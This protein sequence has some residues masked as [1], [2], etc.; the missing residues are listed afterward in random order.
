MKR[1]ILILLAANF[2]IAIMIG[3][4]KSVHDSKL[5]SKNISDATRVAA[6][7]KVDDGYKS[8]TLAQK[9]SIWT[10]EQ[11]STK[12]V[13][14]GS[15][16]GG[17]ALAAPIIPKG[18]LAEGGGQTGGTGFELEVDFNFD[19]MFPYPNYTVSI[20]FNMTFTVGGGWS[21]TQVGYNVQNYGAWIGGE[22][23]IDP[24][25]YVHFYNNSIVFNLGISQTST[26]GSIN[27]A[28]LTTFSGWVQIN[29]DKTVGSGQCTQKP[30]FPKKGL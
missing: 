23:K 13:Y 4:N 1:T 25:S 8:L 18:T 5:V 26:F 11:Y 6:N 9:E 12:I 7:P 2:T 16:S 14:V 24:N 3:C 27:N 15:S 29:D 21:I 30:K 19:N 22:L 17:G 20:Y 28:A 10:H